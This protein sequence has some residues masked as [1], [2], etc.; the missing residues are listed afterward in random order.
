VIYVES[1]AKK[2]YDIRTNIPK[3]NYELIWTDVLTGKVIGKGSTSGQVI[4]MPSAL[5]DKVVVIRAVSK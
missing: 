2:T 5:S 1:I 4:K 3:G